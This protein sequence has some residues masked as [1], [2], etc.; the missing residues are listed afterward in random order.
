MPLGILTVCVWGYEARTLTN[1]IAVDR[2]GVA[3]RGWDSMGPF[4]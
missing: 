4:L 2:T 1:N 3:Y